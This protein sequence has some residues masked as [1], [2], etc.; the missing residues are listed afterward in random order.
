MTLVFLQSTQATAHHYS[1]TSLE[2][3]LI[4]ADGEW[5]EALSAAP[6]EQFNFVKVSKHRLES[7]TSFAFFK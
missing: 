4:S 3:N 7:T 5:E 2:M 6:M 1:I